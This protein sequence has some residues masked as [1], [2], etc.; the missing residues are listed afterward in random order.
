M[1]ERAPF[2]GAGLREALRLFRHETTALRDAG[3]SLETT[4]T[5]S[6]PPR[7]VSSD[8]I[9]G[10]TVR[11]HRVDEP[12]T[13]GFSA[14]LDGVQESHVV[15]YADGVPIVCG[16]VSAVVRHRLLRRLVTWKRPVVRS[17][18]YVP[19]VLVSPGI[20][21]HAIGSAF[22]V[23]DTTEATDAAGASLSSAQDAHPFTVAQ[24]AL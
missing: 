21:S 8:V 24:R 19:R 22:E 11:A 1:T 16:R 23:V 18:L 12:P 3:P 14:F 15:H 7:V 10:T 6:E 17:R 2:A 5:P 20:W 4:V 9:E 13:V